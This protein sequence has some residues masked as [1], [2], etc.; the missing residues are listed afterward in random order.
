VEEL[1]NARTK[2]V[3]LGR[4]S[5]PNECAGLIW[6]LLADEA[7]YMKGQA[8]KLHLVNEGEQTMKRPIT[9]CADGLG[10]PEGPYELHEG[11]VIYANIFASAIGV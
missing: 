4:G 10:R 8:I 9:V 7:A 6:F 1:D 2:L 5:S 11:R 3:P